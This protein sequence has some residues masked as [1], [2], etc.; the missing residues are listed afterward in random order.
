MNLLSTNQ[1]VLTWLCIYPADDSTRIEIKLAYI[2]V[3]I[4]I[5][6]IELSILI[7]SIAF[8]MKNV[9]SDLDSSLFAV[10]QIVGLFGLTYMIIVAFILSR[11]ITDMFKGL[12]LICDTC[13]NDDSFKFLEKTNIKIEQIWQIYLKY[14][15]GG[16]AVFIIVDCAIYACICRLIY[17]NVNILAYLYRPFKMM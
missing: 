4:V 8:F 11:N 16:C 14:V 17:G 6:A 2:I 13:A 9:S 10:I 12:T 5:I 1:R 7:A 3:S 15:M